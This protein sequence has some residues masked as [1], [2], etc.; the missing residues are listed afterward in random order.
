MKFIYFL[1]A[2]VLFIPFIA[3]AQTRKPNIVL[4]V[5]DDQGY[6]DLGCVGNDGIKTPHLDQ[7]AKE[8]TV[9]RNFYAT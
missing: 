1:I 7:L 9:F 5:S 2:F 8:G 6:H 3:S 4:I